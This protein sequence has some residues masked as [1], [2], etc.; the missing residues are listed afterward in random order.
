VA[1]RDFILRRASPSVAAEMEA[2]SRTWMVRCRKCGTERSIWDMGGIRYKAA[3]KPKRL[4]RCTTC[5]RRRWADVYR[6][7]PTAA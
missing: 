3:G 7:P 2:E 6:K 4:I 1:L 5:G